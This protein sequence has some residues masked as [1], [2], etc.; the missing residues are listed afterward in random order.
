MFHFYRIVESSTIFFIMQEF[1]E[2]EGLF[3]FL[4]SVDFI[5]FSNY[6]EYQHFF[7][8]SKC[9]LSVLEFLTQINVLKK[10]KT[11]DFKMAKNLAK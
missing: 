6:S 9:Q 3:T 1:S 8:F 10:G 7:F 4:E 11:N 5:E 2:N